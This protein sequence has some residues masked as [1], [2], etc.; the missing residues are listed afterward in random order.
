MGKLLTEMKSELLPQWL[1]LLQHLSLSRNCG[2]PLV[3]CFHCLK[4]QDEIQGC[5]TPVGAGRNRG[6]WVGKGCWWSIMVALALRRGG[7]CDT[8]ASAGC[9]CPPL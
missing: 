6:L 3:L 1:S 8:T 5:K 7:P 4:V 9:F 2:A